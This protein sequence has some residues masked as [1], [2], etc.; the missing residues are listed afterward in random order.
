MSQIQDLAEVVGEVKEAAVGHDI[1]FRLVVELGGEKS[2]PGDVVAKVNELLT[3][4]A[5]E[6]EMR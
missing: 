3:G 5:E 4:V 6:L 1:T 2:A